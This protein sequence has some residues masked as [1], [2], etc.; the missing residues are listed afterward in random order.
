[1]SRRKARE[2]ALQALFQL[3]FNKVDQKD[4]VNAA[5]SESEILSDGAR[6]YAQKIVEDTLKDLEQIDQIIT[7]NSRDWKIERMSGVDRNITRIAV[8]E[9]KFSEEKIT[10]NIVIN[11]AVELAKKFGSDESARF[12]NGVLDSIAKKNS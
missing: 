11:E 9:M 10:P 5:L 7:D 2:T 1:M 4:A 12:V 6:S 3:D 8:Y